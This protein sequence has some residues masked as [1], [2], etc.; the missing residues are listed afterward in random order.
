MLTSK[1]N[2]TEMSGQL[3]ELKEKENLAFEEA[4]RCKVCIYI[5]YI[6]PS[7]LHSVGNCLVVIIGNVEH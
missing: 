7:I 4:E 6:L 3:I 2:F 5:I 1:G